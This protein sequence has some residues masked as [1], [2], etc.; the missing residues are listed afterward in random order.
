MST[1]KNSFEAIRLFPALFA[2]VIM[3]SGTAGALIVFFLQRVFRPS[4][5]P[6]GHMTSRSLMSRVDMNGME[7]TRLTLLDRIRGGVLSKL[8]KTEVSPLGFR[9]G[10]FQRTIDNTRALIVEMAP[11]KKA[12]WLVV[13]AHRGD[14]GVKLEFF[15]ENTPPTETAGQ[16]LQVTRLILCLNDIRQKHERTL[17]IYPH[18][19]TVVK[20]V[21]GPSL[22]T[23][24]QNQVICIEELWTILDEFDRM[25]QYALLEVLFETHPILLEILS[26]IATPQGNLVEQLDFQ[27]IAKELEDVHQILLLN[28]DFHKALCSGTTP[29]L[30]EQ[31]AAATTAKMEDYFSKRAAAY[32]DMLGKIQIHLGN[33]LV[34]EAKSH[35]QYYQKQWSFYS[36]DIYLAGVKQ[37]WTSY[38]NSTASSSRTLTE[39]ETLQAFALKFLGLSDEKKNSITDEIATVCFGKHIGY[40][41]TEGMSWPDGEAL[42]LVTT[43]LSTF[44]GPI[45]PTAQTLA[46]PEGKKQAVQ[47]LEKIKVLT[48]EAG[49]LHHQGIGVQY[50]CSMIHSYCQGTVLLLANESSMNTAIGVL[51][52]MRSP[53]KHPT[54]KVQPQQSIAPTITP[55]QRQQVL[56]KIKKDPFLCV[57]KLVLPFIKGLLPKDKHELV[58]NFEKHMGILRRIFDKSALREEIIQTVSDPVI[59]AFLEKNGFDGPFC[60]FLNSASEKVHAHFSSVAEGKTALGH[61]P[62]TE[63]PVHLLV[64]KI[65]KAHSLRRG[66]FGRSGKQAFEGVQGK[67]NL[68]ENVKA[69]K[70]T[71]WLINEL[72]QDV[73][74]ISSGLRALS[75]ACFFMGISFGPF[76]IGTPLLGKVLA[77]LSE[78]LKSE[79]VWNFIIQKLQKADPDAPLAKLLKELKPEETTEF[80]DFLANCLIPLTTVLTPILKE[81]HKSLKQYKEFFRYL[82]EIMQNT[83]NQ[84]LLKIEIAKVIGLMMLEL[85][86]YGPQLDAAFKSF[87]QNLSQE[88]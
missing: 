88:V 13:F 9:E 53:P 8:W 39:S 57:S 7:E 47:L 86:A 85:K 80:V 68:E 78:S 83:I 75:F 28:P 29:E 52:S 17:S 61:T 33:G 19:G 11:G 23:L 58:G 40:S 30:K 31:M 74:D 14:L 32:Q 70:V 6:H 25:K 63:E 60:E 65:V 26:H 20:A 73:K 18:F 87:W 15:L 49:H 66:L 41:L 55:A 1:I 34:E 59:S 77:T 4:Y 79:S 36:I 10:V 76:N 51:R 27:A 84:D 24:C 50:L 38:H 2:S 54:I 67:V 48:L 44:L 3:M 16:K 56:E 82:N 69:D 72:P 62:V 71:I 43:E 21:V 12:D 64:E 37:A 22:K 45:R 42:H 81:R 5:Q 35:Y 46:T